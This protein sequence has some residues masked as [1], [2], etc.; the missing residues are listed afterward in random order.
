MFRSVFIFVPIAYLAYMSYIMIYGENKDPYVNGRSTYGHYQIE[1]KC[2][3]CHS[4]PFGG[5]KSLNDSCVRCHSGELEASEDTHP[6]KLFNDPRNELILSKLN[7]RSCI[8]CHKEH[9]D[10]EKKDGGV[11][12]SK[13][14]C[15]TCHNNIRDER[16][17]HKHVDDRS[18]ANGGCHNYHDNRALYHEYVVGNSIGENVKSNPI[19]NRKSNYKKRSGDIAINKLSGDVYYNKVRL[20]HKELQCNKC[21]IDDT[22]KQVK[23]SVQAC[24]KCHDSEVS[25]FKISR[26]GMRYA[27]KMGPIKK[28]IIRSEMNL[29]SDMFLH[30]CNLCHKE[31]EVS[32][33]LVCLDCHND[34]HSKNY[35]N[36]PHGGLHKKYLNGKIDENR[37]VTCITCHMYRLEQS[38]GQEN[39]ALVLT[40]N[41]NYNLRPNE[42][43]I[44]P[45]CIN[46][47]SLQFAFDSLSDYSVIL[48]NFSI[49]PSKKVKTI[50][51][52]LNSE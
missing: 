50:E 49:S 38:Y 26:H 46:C 18:C 43:M 6:I 24:S 9:W 5:V 45:V 12:Q 33:P 36:S 3:V 15:V 27:A 30:D 10:E 22:D 14:F 48:S 13:E 19:I 1:T 47:H 39:N 52:Y 21:H 2:E 35:E 44:R 40:H 42:K 51:W 37:D 8:E 11:S 29:P 31:H 17:S 32:K 41:V 25:E 28:T 23:P 4:Q 16:E 20:I 7:A 34:Q